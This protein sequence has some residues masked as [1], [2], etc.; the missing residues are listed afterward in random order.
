MRA[1]FVKKGILFLAILILCWVAVSC[2]YGTMYTSGT[3]VW[4]AGIRSG[5]QSH[6]YS[7]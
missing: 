7:Y 1:R 5:V 3:N 6:Y 4:D 2:G